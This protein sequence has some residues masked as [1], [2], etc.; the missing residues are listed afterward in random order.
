MRSSALHITA[1][2][3]ASYARTNELS[4]QELAQLV[5]R[6]RS[7]IGD[8]LLPPPAVPIDSSVAREFLICLE[9]GI[10]CKSLR[11]HLNK[12]HA[13]MSVGQYFK[14]WRLPDS[15]PIVAPAF[16]DIS[17]RNAKTHGLGR[18]GRR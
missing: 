7:T 12:Y 6:V 16:A 14:R 18:A 17:S 15:Y 1:D 2:I 8:I 11:R 4:P 13:P 9:D 3:V 10:R 5:C